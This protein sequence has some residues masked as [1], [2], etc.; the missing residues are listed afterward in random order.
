MREEPGLAHAQALGELAE[1]EPVEPDL[2]GERD[3][4]VEDGRP[5]ALAT[6]QAPVDR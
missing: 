6:G 2:G 1:G 4:G 5:G 3:G